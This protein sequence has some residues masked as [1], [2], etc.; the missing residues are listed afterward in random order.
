MK[1]S[2]S[3]LDLMRQS[4]GGVVAAAAISGAAHANVVAETDRAAAGAIPSVCASSE[5]DG[6]SSNVEK[7]DEP[8]KE[9][10]KKERK[11][12]PCPTCGMG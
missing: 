3:T 2:P 12:D 8:K 1:L 7:K 6:V 11:Q 10:P 5:A 9:E 4:V